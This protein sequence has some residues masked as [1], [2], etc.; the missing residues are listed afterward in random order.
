M[1]GLAHKPTVERTDNEIELR[2]DRHGVPDDV[3]STEL[4][5]DKKIALHETFGTAPLVSRDVRHMQSCTVQGATTMCMSVAIDV[6]PT[7]RQAWL[8]E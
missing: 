5:G 4:L 3:N 6:L 8:R 1:V 2:L 7:L